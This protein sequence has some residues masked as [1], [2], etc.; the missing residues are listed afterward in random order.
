MELNTIIEKIKQNY[1]VERKNI[2]YM[3]VGTAAGY[4]ETDGTLADK[5]YH[6][7]P[8][9]LQHIKNVIPNVS[10]S[11]ILIDPLQEQPPYMVRDKGLVV[12]GANAM[13]ANAYAMGANAY[14]MGPTYHSQDHSLTLYTFREYV[15]TDP[16]INHNDHN[17]NITKH[18]RELNQ[19]A[20]EN[21]AVLLY[22]DFTGRNNRLL[23]EYFDTE[24]QHHLDHVI[25]GFGLREDMGCYFDLTTS[26]AYYPFTLDRSG[27]IKLVNVYDYIVNDK[28]N[29]MK[30]LTWA[31]DF[32]RDIYNAH[33]EKIL[34]II[35][36]QLHNEMLYTLLSVF[37]LI[38][39]EKMTDYDDGA[40]EFKHLPL[41]KRNTCLQLM[42]HKQ[43]GDIYE[44]L[45]ADYSKTLDVVT[46]IKELGITGQE[47]LEFITLGDDPYKW[48][49]HV[50]D[51][52]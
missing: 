8:P 32:N 29:H 38:M 36:Q 17:I 9:F 15:Y 35:K 26:A 48:Y 16:Y 1:K 46:F 22:H 18:L 25:Y 52:F 21:N 41:T 39:G 33:I 11:I 45:F 12:V 20:I 7:Y 4:K 3:G 50:K 14:A 51:F 42:S 43:Y 31:D 5:H 24:I 34:I 27:H 47:M 19:F 23:A 37:R 10:I 28:I 40:L 2:I 30:R 13:G 49:N 44:L 6:Q